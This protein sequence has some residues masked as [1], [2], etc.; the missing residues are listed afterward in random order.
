MGDKKP[1]TRK[2]DPKQA[3]Q[4]R[5]Q[6]FSKQLQPQRIEQEIEPATPETVPIDSWGEN[7]PEASWGK[8]IQTRGKEHPA[9]LPM[10][11]L[12]SSDASASNAPHM[13]STHDTTPAREMPRQ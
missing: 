9:D 1:S 3:D 7:A 8:P 2:T 5:K 13:D 10:T 11:S 6:A 12:S 4:R